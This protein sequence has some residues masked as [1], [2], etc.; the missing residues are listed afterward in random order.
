[1]DLE[2]VLGTGIRDLNIL[3]GCCNSQVPVSP[4]SSFHHF[5]LIVF[6]QRLGMCQPREHW[7]VSSFK[8]F[9]AGLGPKKSLLKGALIK[10]LDTLLM[11]NWL[12]VY[13]SFPEHSQG[14]VILPM[15]STVPGCWYWNLSR[16]QAP[17]S[18]AFKLCCMKRN[19][20]AR[21][22]NRDKFWSVFAFFKEY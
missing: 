8:G 5:S 15:F 22:C 18:P 2:N 1:M 3:Y 4:G 17:R 21:K 19:R 10:C 16:S 20:S 6:N 13:V 11:V 9:Q 14:K 7:D 12:P